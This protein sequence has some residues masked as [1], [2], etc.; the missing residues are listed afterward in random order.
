MCFFEGSPY[1]YKKRLLV[2]Q[3]KIAGYIQIALMPQKGLMVKNQCSACAMQ[4]AAIDEL[5][6]HVHE[7]SSFI[8]FIQGLSIPNDTATQKIYLHTLCT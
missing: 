2:S 1:K 8:E 7:C 5:L 4:Y 3:F 6:Q